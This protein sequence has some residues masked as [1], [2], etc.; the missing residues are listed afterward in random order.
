MTRKRSTNLRYEFAG[1]QGYICCDNCGT[2]GPCDE[3]AADPHCNIEAA[4][5][6]WNHRATAARLEGGS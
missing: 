2:Q 1:S 4:E 5:A 3:Q 6:A